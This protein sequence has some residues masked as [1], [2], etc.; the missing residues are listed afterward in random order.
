MKTLINFVNRKL[1]ELE[2][3]EFTTYFSLIIL[4]VTITIIFF[5]LGIMHLTFMQ[6][7]M[8]LMCGIMILT[9]GSVIFIIN[10]GKYELSFYVMYFLMVIYIIF[11]IQILGNKTIAQVFMLYFIVPQFTY[12]FSK[13]KK[14]LINITSLIF[15]IYMSFTGSGEVTINTYNQSIVFA[16]FN[17]VALYVV[18]LIQLSST[19]LVRELAD[20]L[21]ER[22]LEFF[23]NK[24]QFDDLTGLANRFYA[25]SYFA[26]ISN[27]KINRNYIVAIAD[28]DDFKK[29]NDSYGHSVGDIVLKEVSK[30]A[31]ARFRKKD[32]ICRWGG[33]EFLIVL[34][35]INLDSAE[36]ILNR[37]R[38]D[39]EMISIPADNKKITLTL[40]IG[41]SEI[42]ERDVNHSIELADVNLYKGKNNGKNKVVI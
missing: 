3:E 5:I 27:K 33:E 10:K 40:T 6:L 22:E 31:K 29:I 11:K 32:L 7:N 2:T 42:K 14:L 17:I 24:S 23:K 8:A 28:I 16:K 25:N 26:N 1:D 30:V 35:G 38:E 13:S 19:T 41:V 15:M 37:F 21:K 20:K 4:S 18:L 34:E 39:V 9:Y 36:S 12:N